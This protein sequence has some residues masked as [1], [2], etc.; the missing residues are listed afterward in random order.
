[1]EIVTKEYLQDN[2]KAY[3]E[4][5]GLDKI[6][7]ANG[8]AT[9]DAE[10]KVPAS[11]I[12]E[13]I[14]GSSVTYENQEV[15]SIE[16]GENVA[17]EYVDGALTITSTASGGSS[18]AYGSDTV[19]AINAG[20]NVSMSITSGTLTIDA[21]NQLPTGG[22]VGDILKRTADGAAW[23]TASGGTTLKYDSKDVTEIAVGVG[24]T[25]VYSATNKKLTIKRNDIWDTSNGH[26]GI[27]GA[28]NALLVKC[29]TGAD[30]MIIQSKFTS[31]VVQPSGSSSSLTGTYSNDDIIWVT[32]VMGEK[33]YKPLGVKLKVDGAT[34]SRNG[35]IF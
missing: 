6:G 21:N 25:Q 13:G 30:Y 24:L 34:V 12:P 15:T 4:Y 11:Q 18:V 23:E 14:T 3:D 9:L 19:T 20:S 35:Y 22:S 33:M 16:A 28:S 27:S 17:M 5:R 10:G 32:I 31:G 7:K 26:V 2:I 29:P 8:I 1:M